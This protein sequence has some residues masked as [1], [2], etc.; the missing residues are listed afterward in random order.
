MISISFLT[1]K[2]QT[3]DSNSAITDKLELKTTT[4]L[5]AGLEWSELPSAAVPVSP[6]S[7]SV[8]V[9]EQLKTLIREIYELQVSPQEEEDE[10]T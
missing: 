6:F 2:S 8:E 3:V 4:P 9:S 1:Q 7:S 10:G 5:P